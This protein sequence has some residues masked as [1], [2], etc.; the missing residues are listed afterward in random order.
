MS[1]ILLA[2]VVTV[3][4][5]G[6]L[7][8]QSLQ[9]DGTPQLVGLFTAT[10]I[11]F[12]GDPTNLR[13]FMKEHH[14]PELSEQA[15]AIFLRNHIGVGFDASNKVTR[16]ALVSED[17]G[18]CSAFAGQAN[19]SDLLPSLTLMLKARGLDVAQDGGKEMGKATAD[20]Y[21]VKI[22]DHLYKLVVSENFAPEAAVQAAITLSP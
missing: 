22:N 1:K 10:C 19:A 6:P 15:R 2:G 21:K 18:V 8:G 13:E 4:T 16:L 14:V 5:A 7:L 11:H 9:A 3:A 20:F 12:A 17:N